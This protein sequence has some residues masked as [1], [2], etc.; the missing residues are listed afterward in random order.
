MF[1]VNWGEKLDFEGDRIAISVKNNCIKKI[2]K[3]SIEIPPNGYIL[4]SNDNYVLNFLKKKDCLDVKWHSVPDWSG[5]NEAVSGGPYLIMD[6]NVFVDLENQKFK[7][8]KKETYAARSAVGIGKDEKL[9]LIAVDGKKNGYSVGLNLEELASFLKKL[10]LQDAIN[11]D[12]GG[13]TTLV[14]GR[15]IINNL[16]EHHERKISNALLILYKD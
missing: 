7:F 10:N 16:S 5:I 12:G 3:G 9:Y 14:A 2:S 11:L 15:K 8:A 6:G 1:T 4:I 13:S